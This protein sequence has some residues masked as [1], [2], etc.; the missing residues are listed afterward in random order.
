M[1]FQEEDENV[2]SLGTMDD[3]QK[4]TEIAHLEPELK[5]LKVSWN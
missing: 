1:G 3:A 2:K 5:M 4:R